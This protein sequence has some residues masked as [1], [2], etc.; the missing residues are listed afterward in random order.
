MS[1]EEPN[2]I[3]IAALAAESCT[4]RRS[5]KKA[6]LHGPSSVRGLAGVRLARAMAKLSIRMDD[7]AVRL[8]DARR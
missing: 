5:A 8:A 4:D 3:I 6:L 1:H 7:P 2:P